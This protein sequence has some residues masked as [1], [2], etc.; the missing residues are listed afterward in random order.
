MLA[1]CLAACLVLSGVAWNALGW[2]W[3]ILLSSG[4][5]VAVLYVATSVSRA[6][7]WRL[8]W[9]LSALYG[10][11]GVINIQLEAL[12]FRMFSPSEIVRNTV[13]GLAQ[14][15]LVSAILA[16]GGTRR[17]DAANAGHSGMASLLWW[18]VP[19][20]ALTY[21]VLFFVAGSLALPFFRQFYAS[22]NVLVMPPF[23]LLVAAEFLRGLVYV[24]A[25]TPLMRRLAGRRLQAALVAGLSLSILGGIAPLLMPVDSI[26]PAAVRRIHMVE[27]FGANFVLGV[28]A[29]FLLVRRA[30]EARGAFAAPA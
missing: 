13:S 19:V 16:L 23:G 7:G 15:A 28:I 20:I 11:I 3:V 10:G 26:L 6:Q 14:A 29:A 2:S 27:I 18:R 24:V 9:M 1:A 30:P 25:L 22:S 21:V 12:V 17:M 8:F 5:T 4:L